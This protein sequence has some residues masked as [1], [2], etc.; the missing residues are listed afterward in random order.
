M[1]HCDFDEWLC[2]SGTID[3]M[4]K[5]GN[6]IILGDFKTNKKID[7]ESY[8]DRNTRKRQMMRSPVNDLM[9]CSLVHYQLQLSMYAYMLQHL[10]PKFNI[11]KLVIIH[12]DHD[13]KITEYEVEY[14]KDHVARL[15]LD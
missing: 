10:Y 11:K 5:D 7:T 15:L 1:I 3:I 2:V 14:L 12:I 4:L 13:D 8:F 9:D 6:D